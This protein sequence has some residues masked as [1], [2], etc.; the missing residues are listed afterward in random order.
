L[1]ARPRANW[2]SGA[3]GLQEPIEIG[4]FVVELLANEF[5]PL[6]PI[7]YLMPPHCQERYLEVLALPLGDAC[8]S[9]REGRLERRAGL[10]QSFVETLRIREAELLL[11][12]D[13]GELDLGRD[14]AGRL[15]DHAQLGAAGKARGL[16]E[17]NQGAAPP[18]LH[19]ERGLDG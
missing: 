6:L 7:K 3:D 18:V 8:G 2:R 9:L 1:R 12:A 15:V 5:G 10:A 16:V 14:E 17:E 13:H 4:Q 19:G 11:L